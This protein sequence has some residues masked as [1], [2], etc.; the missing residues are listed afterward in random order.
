MLQFFAILITVVFEI[1]IIIVF[2]IMIAVVFALVIS[3]FKNPD[4]SMTR[5]SETKVELEP[6]IEWSM[7]KM[8]IGQ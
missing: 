3:F 1:L 6:L 5:M 2:A 8:H 4:W 7:T